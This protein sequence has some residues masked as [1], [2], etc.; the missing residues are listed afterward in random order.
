MFLPSIC[1]AVHDTVKIWATEL[2]SRV[3]EYI[4][5]HLSKYYSGKKQKVR[6]RRWSGEEMK[7]W[8]MQMQKERNE[9]AGIIRNE[10]RQDSDLFEK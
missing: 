6:I 2:L 5:Y 10:S 8:V 9:Q 7:S 1:V 4:G 3:Q